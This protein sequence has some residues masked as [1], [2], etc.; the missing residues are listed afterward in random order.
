LLRSALL[1]FFGNFGQYLL[2]LPLSCFAFSFSGIHK[3]VLKC[4]L[5]GQKLFE[6]GQAELKLNA[7]LVEVQGMH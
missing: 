6:R 3:R 1:F 5:E 7:R 2:L 4:S